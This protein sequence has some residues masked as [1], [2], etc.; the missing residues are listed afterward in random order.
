MKRT[1]PHAS[2]ANKAGWQGT[3]HCSFET[4]A[5]E[6]EHGTASESASN[7]QQRGFQVNDGSLSPRCAGWGTTDRGQWRVTENNR[8]PT[9]AHRAGTRHLRSEPGLGVRRPP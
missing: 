5:L 4:L 2:D 7:N 9:H 8:A 1:A 6:D 3:L